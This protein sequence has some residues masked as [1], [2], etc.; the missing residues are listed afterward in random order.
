MYTLDDLKTP[1]YHVLQ[2]GEQATVRV[3][4]AEFK[5]NTFKKGRK[6]LRLGTV[7]VNGPHE[8]KLINFTKNDGSHMYDILRGALGNDDQKLLAC[9]NYS[10]GLG[11]LIGLR[12]VITGGEPKHDKEK[13]QSYTQVA[14]VDF[15]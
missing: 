9:L 11:R 13:N 1:E 3:D 14:R 6:N 12:L 8:G 4:T 5:E 7:I 2:K 10:E 15:F